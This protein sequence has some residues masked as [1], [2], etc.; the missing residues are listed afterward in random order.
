[1][2]CYIH[3]NAKKYISGAL[4]R[5]SS[6]IGPGYSLGGCGS[7]MVT[8]RRITRSYNGILNIK[9]TLYTHYAQNDRC[10]SYINKSNY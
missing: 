4:C 8:Y 2:N 5:T 6:T 10:V 3:I 7:A 9:L 1:M